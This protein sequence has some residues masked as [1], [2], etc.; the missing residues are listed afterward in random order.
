MKLNC[1]TCPVAKSAACAALS[2]EERAEFA[3]HGRSRLLAKGETLFAAGD[4]LQI[5]AT[6]V[7]GALKIAATDADGVERI[8]SLVHPAGFIGELFAPFPAYDVTALTESEVCLFARADFEAAA[9]RHPGLGLA[10][11][12]RA[13]DDLHDARALLDLSR[14]PAAR[15]RVAGLLLAFARAA[16]DSPCHA[17]QA[18]ELPLGRGEMAAML[19]LTIETVSRQLGSLE[20]AGVIRRVGARGVELLDPASLGGLAE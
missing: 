11:L 18:V 14:R 8:L 6:L 2:A 17:A 7:R 9:Q 20:A 1:A 15:A 12:H 10:L 19:G 16:S 3:R 4:D 5:C 13:Q